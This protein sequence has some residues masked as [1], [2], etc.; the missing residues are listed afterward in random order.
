MGVRSRSSGRGRWGLSVWSRGGAW[1]QCG[2]VSGS[3]G[4]SPIKNLVG[5][6][7]NL[8]DLAAMIFCPKLPFKN[9]RYRAS[10]LRWRRRARRSGD[11][12][13]RMQACSA[14]ICWPAT[15]GT[16]STVLAPSLHLRLA[17]LCMLVYA[18]QSMAAHRFE[19][20]QTVCLHG[21]IVK[22]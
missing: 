10:S 8:A 6:I 22:P 9:P 20:S 12:E 18:S 1:V 19:A 3:C 11:S 2:C 21:S 4:Y 17:A 7:Q 14:L 15:G 13:R 5:G 16:P